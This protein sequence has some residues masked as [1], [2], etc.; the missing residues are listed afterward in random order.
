MY[1]KNKAGTT[2]IRLSSGKDFGYKIAS[3]MA[4]LAGVKSKK[5]DGSTS[6]VKG[7][8]KASLKG[9][10]KTKQTSSDGE[11]SDEE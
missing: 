4:T 5:K 1:T 11:S 8:K 9:S 3:E 2:P 7:S 10:K 6:S